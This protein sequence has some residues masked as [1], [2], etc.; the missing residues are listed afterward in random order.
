MRKSYPQHGKLCYQ[1]LENL[2]NWNW[3]PNITVEYES[4]LTS[5]GK[6]DIK[7]LAKR[8]QTRFPNLLGIPY[9][10]QDFVV[11]IN[12]VTVASL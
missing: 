5:Q 10:E 7:Y 6:D 8:Y 12:R 2:K 4:F 11:S 3:D 1:D 9:N